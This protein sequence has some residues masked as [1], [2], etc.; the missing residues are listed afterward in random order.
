M[1]IQTSELKLLLKFNVRYMQIYEMLEKAY[2]SSEPPKEWYEKNIVH[3]MAF[4][5]N[6]KEVRL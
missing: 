3:D 1:P 6:E 2:N 5:Y 4:Y